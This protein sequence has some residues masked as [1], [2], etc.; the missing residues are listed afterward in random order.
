MKVVSCANLC[1]M[2]KYVGR[3]ITFI[4]DREHNIVLNGHCIEVT[5]TGEHNSMVMLVQRTRH[6]T[7]HGGKQVYRVPERNIISV[8]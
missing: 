7:G 4:Y 3:T 6:R 1:E 8:K 5:H 2:G